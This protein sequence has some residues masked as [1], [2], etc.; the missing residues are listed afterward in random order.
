MIARGLAPSAMRIPNSCVRW[1]TACSVIASRPIADSA[2]AI[3]A[4]EL[5]NPCDTRAFQPESR[6]TRASVM[7]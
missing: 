3:A 2:S 1:A 4:M 6:S 7:T 5:I